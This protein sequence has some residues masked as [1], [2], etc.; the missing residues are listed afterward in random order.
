MTYRQLDHL[1][2]DLFKLYCRTILDV[3]ITINKGTDNL[4][5]LKGCQMLVL[6]K[7]NLTSVIFFA[8]FSVLDNKYRSNLMFSG[9]LRGTHNGHFE[10]NSASFCTNG[11]EN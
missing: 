3:C 11:A 10:R 2:S 4:R 6:T 8:D 5:K 7:V 9:V 1:E